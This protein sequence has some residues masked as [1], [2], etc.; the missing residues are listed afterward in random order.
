MDEV[1]AF[2]S[3]IPSWAGSVPMW[4]LLATVIGT[5]IKTWPAIM[6]RVEVAK[7]RKSVAFKDRI[8]EL[9]AQVKDCW[10][11]CDARDAE[12]TR[13]I[14]GLHDEIFGLRKQHMQEQISFARAILDSLGKDSPQLSVLLKAME[15]GQRSLEAAHLKKQKDVHELT[16]VTGDAKTDTAEKG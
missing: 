14:R 1:T 8:A 12:A 9:E 6:E 5:L 3:G 7:A 13:E 15:N 2:M 16:G 11:K 4:F 10:E